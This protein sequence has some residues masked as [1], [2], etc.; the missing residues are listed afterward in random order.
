MFCRNCGKE[1][2]DDSRVC[3]YCGAPIAGDW[4]RTEYRQTQNI[5]GEPKVQYS[6]GTETTFSNSSYQGTGNPGGT[7]YTQGSWNQN[8]YTQGTGYGTPQN[9]DGNCV[10]DSWNCF[11]SDFLLCQQV[12]ADHYRG[13]LQYCTWN[14]IHSEEFRRKGNGDSRNR[15]QLCGSCDGTDR[16]GS[17]RGAGFGDG[18]IYLRY[19]LIDSSYLLYN[20]KL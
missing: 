6:G 11:S 10:H 8:G 14:F 9:M 15:M 19:V 17:W 3:G 1:I 7:Q 4:Q 12:V 5:Y 20:C 13:S 16:S 18:F 2:A